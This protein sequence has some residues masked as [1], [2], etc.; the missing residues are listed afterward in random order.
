MRADLTAILEAGGRIRVL[1]L[2]PTDEALIETA[3][4]RLAHFVA[5][6]ER[7]WDAGTEWPL[8]PAD[9]AARARRP[10]FS[11]EFGAE[12]DTAMDGTADLLV[13]GVARSIFVNNNYR[14]LEKKLLAGQKIRFVVADPDSPAIDMAA[15][16]TTPAGRRKASGSGSNI[17]FG[18]WRS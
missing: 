9:A 7:M 4:R 15:D 16:G 8:S 12:L 18:C 3:D 6:A 10:V 2:D 5:E 14:R 13:T 17:C 1:V 11:T